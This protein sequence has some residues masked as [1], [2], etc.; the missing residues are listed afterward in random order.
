[1]RIVQRTRSLLILR[2][3]PFDVWILTS[4]I[5]TTGFFIILIEPKF[6]LLGAIFIALAYFW[7]LKA[8]SVTCSLNKTEG[9]LTLK[10]QSLF[11]TNIVEYHLREIRDVRVEKRIASVKWDAAYRA[12]IVFGS[13]N[14][15]PI[16]S[17]YS[18]GRTSVQK[19]VS[20]IKDFLNL[21]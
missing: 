4:I 19:T 7:L 16:T 9:T 3:K 17:Y 1:M 6:S 11:G 14:C 18:S 12:S 8:P 20:C 15:L 10:R 13:G 2:F 5:V 21:D